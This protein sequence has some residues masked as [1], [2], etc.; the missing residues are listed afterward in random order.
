[1]FSYADLPIFVSVFFRSFDTVRYDTVYHLT[2]V[3]GNSLLPANVVKIIWT[4]LVQW[5]VS[6]V[7]TAVQCQ[8]VTGWL[9]P[10]QREFSTSFPLST[11]HLLMHL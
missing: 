5:C 2:D 10:I 4:Y 7:T 11:P 3:I 9:S 8:F 6:P 1:M